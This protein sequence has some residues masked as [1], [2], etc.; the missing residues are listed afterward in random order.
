MAEFAVAIGALLIMALAALAQSLIGMTSH[1]RLHAVA[2]REEKQQRTVKSLLDPRRSLSSSMLVIQVLGAI[3]AAAVLTQLF[4]AI[5]DYDLSWVAIIVVGCVYLVLGQALPRALA[6]SGADRYLGWVLHVARVGMAAIWPLTWLVDRVAFVIA[7]TIPGEPSPVEFDGFEEELRRRR[8]RHPDDTIGVEEQEMID[9]V[10]HL[11]KMT[12]RDIMVPR[13][14]MVA[15]DRAVPPHQ[16]VEL[17]VKAGHSRI[18]VYQGSIDRVLGVLYAKDLLPFVIGNTSRIPLL[19]LIRPAVVVPESKRVSDMFTELKRQRIH[20]AIVADEYG[21]TAGLVTIEDIL[22]E[23]VGEI[24]DEYDTEQ[25]LFEL[26]EPSVLLAD[27]RLPIEDVEEALH[28]HFE[29]DDDFGTLGGFVHKH[30][31]RLPMQGDVFTAEGVRVEI[32]TVERHRVRELRL[33]K[34]SLREPDGTQAAQA[35]NGAEEE[36]PT[37]PFDLDD[38][39]ARNRGDDG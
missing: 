8:N 28:L 36:R 25:P 10:F 27:G 19:D 15:V 22:E 5:S 33:T 30:L 14:D 38:E 17:I 11:E 9:G 39:Q 4:D 29:E 24:Q 18:P 21:G 37:A 23:I 12:V 2:A 26:V 1:K 20:I 32:L 7:G 13:L 6:D 34:L 16:L 31:G 35:D 3:V